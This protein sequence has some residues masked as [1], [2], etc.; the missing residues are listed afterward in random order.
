MSETYYQL[1]SLRD[2]TQ[3]RVRHSLQYPVRIQNFRE[4]E[5]RKESSAIVLHM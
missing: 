2:I 1:H 3:Y 5:E 4:K